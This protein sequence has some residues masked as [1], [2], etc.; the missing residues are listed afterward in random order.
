MT[1]YPVNQLPNT[2]IVGKETEHGV[3]EVRIDCAPWLALWPDMGIS[4]WGT[5]PG[6]DAAYPAATHMEGDVLVWAVGAGDTAKA[7]T[8]CMELMGMAEGKKKLSAI[9]TTRVLGTSTGTTAE[10]PEAAR[11]WVDEVLA[12]RADAEKAAE[13]A[14]DIAEALAGGGGSTDG[15]LFLPSVTEEDNGKL[16]AV[17]DGEWAAAAVEGGTGAEGNGITEISIE[18]V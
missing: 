13:R 4:L 14:E 18:E 12:A 6:G 17:V 1:I 15:G 2:I 11:A 7:G 5:P 9:A 16:L 3:A 8:G 10:P